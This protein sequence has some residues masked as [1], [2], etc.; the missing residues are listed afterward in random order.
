VYKRQ[1][2]ASLG[3][4]CIVIE[5]EE[6]FELTCE[7]PREIVPKIMDTLQK[8]GFDMLSVGTRPPS[9]EDIFYKLTACPIRGEA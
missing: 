7:D 8:S 4:D 1:L 3:D 5:K 9:L 2:L 6:S